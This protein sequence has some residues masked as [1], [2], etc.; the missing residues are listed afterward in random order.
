MK[1]V[2]EVSNLHKSF[3]TYESEGGG[4]LSSIRRTHK[5]TNALNG[6]T[7]HVKKGDIV[8]LIGRNGSGKS[9]LI[10]TITGILYPDLGTVK[11]LGINPW[12]DRKKLAMHIGVVF[13]STHPQLYWNLPPI[14]TFDY[15]KDIYGI[16]NKDYK[17]RLKY[18]IHLF[19]LENVYKK[20][21][22]QLSLGERMKCEMVAAILYLPQLV[23]MD[24]PTIGVDLPARIGIKKMIFQMRKDY[25]TTFLITT[26]VVEDITNVDRIILLDKGKI[27]FSGTQE[28]MRRKLAKNLMLELHFNINEDPRHF[29][30]HGKIIQLKLGYAK[31]EILPS[32]L[33]DKWLTNLLA[34][35]EIIEYRISEPILSTIIER[36]Y[37]SIEKKKTKRKN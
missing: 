25:G 31:I 19:N 14:D 24:E 30:M 3:N 33:K 7:M 15:I 1:Y 21:T 4:I 9:T 2:I 26:H 37:A 34:N 20:Q 29:I 27:I 32:M 18:F 35:K 10:K 8:A 5:K 36:F 16:S 6:V 13:G 22:R 12:K 23:V 28:Y 11:T 17:K